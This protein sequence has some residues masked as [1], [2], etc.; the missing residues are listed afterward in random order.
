MRNHRPNC[1]ECGRPYYRRNMTEQCTRRN[2][3]HRDGWKKEVL[4]ICTNCQGAKISQRVLMVASVTTPPA[5]K[6]R[7]RA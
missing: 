4:R 6:E 3:G 7:K 5:A 1:D 2:P